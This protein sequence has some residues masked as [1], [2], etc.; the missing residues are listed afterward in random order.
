M[1]KKG[2]Y[3]F[4]ALSNGLYYFAFGIFACI[5][6]I[7][8]AGKGHS[9][10]D[11][12][13]ITAAAPLF[14]MVFQPVCG[15]FADLLQSPK[16]V[17]FISAVLC[18]ISGILFAYSDN[19]LFLFLFN[20]ITQGFL[21]GMLAL[22][23]RLAT[24][25][26]YPF[27][28]IR[29]WGSILW[30][31]AA[32]LSGYILDVFPSVT[33]FY[34]FAFS[35]LLMLLATSMVYDVKPEIKSDKKVNTKEVMK[36]LFTNKS[37][38]SFMIIFFIFQGPAGAN[39]IYLPLL[40]QE[41]GGSTT[42]IGTAFLF[43]T[44]SE[45]PAVLFSD[46]ICKKIS[47]RTLMIFAASVSLIRYAWYATMPS[48]TALVSMFFFQGITTIIFILVQVKIIIEIVDP[49]YVNSAYGIS[50]MLGRGISALVFQIGSGFL[51]DAFG[52]SGYS[53]V[54]II[55]AFTMLV[56]ILLSIKYK[57]VHYRDLEQTN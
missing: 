46:R 15:Y 29:L 13:L 32:Q 41:V 22:S 4:Y 1:F 31:V 45:I 23:D 6:S 53:I 16:K 28:S 38:V 18:A 40:I 3:L 17:M 9:A 42:I 21:N 8:L 7:Y 5:I 33:N 50:S 12:S 26:P 34:V 11:I 57:F 27:G 49:Q 25:S 36:Y 2:S 37:F 35:I 10:L 52:R 48:S 43:S 55:F 19:I 54:Y 47:Y 30:A 39:S 44:L 56:T 20:G 24:A 51:I 14:A